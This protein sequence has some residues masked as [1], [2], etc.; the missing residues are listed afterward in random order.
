MNTP[1]LSTWKL[2]PVNIMATGHLERSLPFK[3]INLLDSSLFFSHKARLKYRNSRKTA[4]DAKLASRETISIQFI[5]LFSMPGLI[6]V[7]ILNL[8][9]PATPCCA[10]PP[11]R[12]PQPRI[13]EGD[14]C[15]GRALQRCRAFHSARWEPCPRR[16]PASRGGWR[17]P[18]AAA[19]R[20]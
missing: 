17:A 6:Q 18:G 2:L 3:E 5:L 16:S 8:P 1:Q 14:G 13:V 4:I 15:G 11:H 12:P 9:P 20:A 19:P 10:L 7:Y